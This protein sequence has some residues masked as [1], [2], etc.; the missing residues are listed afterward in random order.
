[1]SE[2]MF[3]EEQ[4]EQLRS[5]PEIT[6]DELIRYFTPTAADVAFVSP[7]GRGPVDRLGM[8]VQLCSLPWLGFVPDDVASVPPAAVA[9]VAER[10]GVASAALRLY[11]KRDQTRSDHL[12]LIAKYLEWQTAS[13]GSQAMKELEQFL[14][15]RAMEHDSPTLLFNLAREYLMAAK[16]IRP[17]A[18]ILAKMVGTAR[19]AAADLTSQLVGH[20]LTA[21]VRAD[22]ERMLAVDA[23][24]GMTRLEWL[25]TPVRDASATS[26]KT[27]I[28]KL[29]WLRAIDAHQMDVSVL[30]NERRRFLAQVARRSTNQGLERRKERKFPILLAFVAQAAVDQL[31]EVVA[32]FDQAV[33]ARESRAKSKTDE[34]LVERAKKGEARQLLMDMILPVLADPS[35]P[36]DEVGGMLR[37]RIGMQR[38]R[39]ITS[40]AW[41][42]LPRDH[43]RLSEL[44]SSY[45]YLRQ[46][47]PNVRAA[48]DFQG[49]PGTAEL[50]EAVA[51][52]K[53]MNRLGGRKVP[54]GAPTGFVPASRKRRAGRDAAVRADR[55]AADRTQGGAGAALAGPGGER[56]DPVAHLAW[57]QRQHQFL[58]GDQCRRRGGVGQARYQRLAAAAARSTA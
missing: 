53:E 24:L 34:A 55:L 46:L 39:E 45:T 37:E 32:L 35:I 48:I 42:P 21:E 57:A 25:V 2:K 7:G 43:G 50:M 9:R 58:R 22:L 49:G 33:S 29:T 3:S 12:G 30:P 27:A 38:L 31:D 15:D 36:D 11:G 54:A 52:L 16:V 18:L 28:D 47:T 23:G 10:L 14:L 56:R 20:L 8:L 17:G 51:V 5:Y 41:K 40:D 26:V 13:A 19:K 1:M 4:L 6:S 44:E